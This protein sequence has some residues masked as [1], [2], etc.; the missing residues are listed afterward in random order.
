MKKL[1]TGFCLFLAG[2][3]LFAEPL[4]RPVM[5]LY[6]VETNAAQKEVAWSTQPGFRYEL[7]ESTNLQTWTTIDGF[8]T[9]AEAL[10]QQHRI[11]LSA[12]SKR[13]FRVRVLDEQPP[14]ILSL[15]PADDA[16]G[17]RRFS[18]ITVTLDDATGIDLSSLSLIVGA[19][20][21]FSAAS[22]ELTWSTNSLVFDLGGDTALGGYGDTID[23]SL[24]VSDTLG[25]STNYVWQF[26]LE[27]QTQTASNMF[28]FGS[29]D[30]QRAGQH[31][32]GMSATLAAR[33]G[34][35]VRM[36]G[37]SQ[38][39]EIDSVTTN[40]IVLAYTNSAPSFSVGQLVAN[41]APSHVSEI[42]YRQI[43]TLS[44]DT[45]N[46]LF[47]LQTTEVTLPDFLTDA[48]FTIG[49]DAVFL[50]IDENGNMVRAL[51][52]DATFQLPDI[53]ADFSGDTLFTSGALTMTMREGK[54]LFHP[55]L[56]VSLKTAWGTV[57]RFE[58]Q[59]AGDLEISC[60]PLIQ[61]TGAYSD[62]LEA[63]LWTWT[64]WIWTAAGFVPVGIELQASIT[65]EATVSTEASAELTAGFRQNADMGVAGRFVRDA[66]P[67][68]TWDRWFN[69]DPFEKVPF[70]YTLNGEG[71]ASLALIPKID[72]RL[73]G[74]AGL[75]LNTDP[76]IEISGSVTMI[77]DELTEADWTLGAYADINAGLSVIG[78]KIGSLPCLPP[79]RVFTKKWDVCYEKEPDPS[80]PPIINAH[81]KSQNAKIGDPVSFSVAASANGVLSYQW[82]HNGKLL[83]GQ[84][85]QT[86]RFRRIG[87]GHQGSYQVRVS[88]QGLSTH[89]SS[90]TLTVVDDNGTGPV[91]AGFVKLDSTEVSMQNMGFGSSGAVF[92]TYYTNPPHWKIINLGGY[93]GFAFNGKK[94]FYFHSLGSTHEGVSYC[95]VKIYING[96]VYISEAFI[97]SSWITYKVPE[98]AF[99]SGHNEI[100]IQLV[101]SP[102]EMSTHFWI[103]KVFVR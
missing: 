74:A 8:P 1:V 45:T 17:V 93:V 72:A 95:H 39:W 50:E 38:S 98:S 22:P 68:V 42:F 7:Q 60:V 21:S 91:V 83:P 28:I 99:D 77:D 6:P 63:E 51:E 48:S 81:P 18:S 13:F 32:S 65:A 29:P 19:H 90:A 2:L 85:H 5:G 89:S 58:A 31:L 59:V 35:P 10:A 66:T 71:S 55:K 67:E 12:V 84:T 100:Y 76:R 73:Y 11:E 3:S 16:F 41:L 56:K 92:D 37:S 47:T 43:N 4:V 102:S 52:L 33:F 80:A 49:E 103:D 86:L 82:Y 34:G 20:G 53:G 78:A 64:H 14:E 61:V 46:K 40:E 15:I 87:V 36:S 27:K 79:F 25:S 88:S 69:V 101:P 9:E 44:D 26:E 97:D 57:E 30:A 70:T 23:I 75:Y 54:F 96:D 62:S 24:A 94:S